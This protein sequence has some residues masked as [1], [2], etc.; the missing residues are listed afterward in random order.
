MTFKIGDMEIHAAVC[1]SL[2]NNT[3]ERERVITEC[4]KYNFEPK[5][6][7]PEKHPT[8]GEQ[9]CL[10]SHLYCI[11][12]ARDNNLENILILEDDIRFEETDLSN[13]K[14][15]KKY[16]MIYLGHNPLTGYRHNKNFIKINSTLTTHAY[17][18]HRSMYNYVLENIGKDWTELP[19]Y[20]QLTPAEQPFFVKGM[21]AIDLFYAK[22]INQHKKNSYGL[23]PM[24]AYQHTGYS[25]IENRHVD[26]SDSFKHR[27]E[28][29][30]SQFLSS[31]QGIFEY[32]SSKYSKMDII[33]KHNATI[34]SC[35]YIL[36]HGPGEK[37]MAETVDIG[38]NDIYLQNSWD[39]YY[40]SPTIYFI[41]MSYKQNLFHEVH[42]FPRIDNVFPTQFNQHTVTKKPIICVYSPKKIYVMEQ[43][44]QMINGAIEDFDI[45]TCTQL[46]T[47]NKHR[48]T[49]THEQYQYLPKHE[50][51]LINDINFFL[52]QPLKN[53]TKIHL[54]ISTNRI[55]KTWNDIQVPLENTGLFY[56]MREHIDS[57]VYSNETIL[58]DFNDHYGLLNRN[59]FLDKTNSNFHQ[60]I[61]NSIVCT[62]NDID[63]ALYKKWHSQLQEHIP[64]LKLY[65]YNS[66]QKSVS[67][68]IFY[69]KG[70]I[71][72][73]LYEMFF[74]N[75]ID[76]PRLIYALR[77]GLVAIGNNPRCAIQTSKDIIEP[78]QAFIAN[79]ERKSI[80]IDT[81]YQIYNNLRFKIKL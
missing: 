30:Y 8:S 52:D 69:M 33:K 6:Y 66:P 43:L 42:S 22:W 45:Y 62:A 29:L 2:K 64:D 10:E 68:T 61:H 67:G 5:F 27:A 31:F 37:D 72:Y 47:K 70:T 38:E 58:H 51:L 53:A 71:E 76:E 17:I 13:V 36:V 9:G 16:D 21:R 1:I 26:Y 39:I 59:I 15:P 34:G 35:D 78:L 77:H 48:N 81:I 40:F 55:N 12:Y 63:I 44:K 46:L 23:Y 4:T 49:I 20:T 74:C 50:L 24:I 11:K 60:K 25:N 32:D 3:E 57:I 18:L 19:E 65:I 73:K 80:F 56:N 54:Y 75:N 7:V 79:T 28:T 14:F 41:R